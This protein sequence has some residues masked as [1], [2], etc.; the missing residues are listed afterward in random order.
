MYCCIYYDL[1]YLYLLVVISQT[2][3]M[4]AA[5]ASGLVNIVKEAIE[6]KIDINAKDSDFVSYN[7][8]LIIFQQ[9]IDS[10]LILQLMK[11]TVDVHIR[12]CAWKSIKF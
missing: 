7:L 8:Q 3:I 9:Q 1:H 6:K 12:L 10:S 5:A 2:E 11:C 4:L